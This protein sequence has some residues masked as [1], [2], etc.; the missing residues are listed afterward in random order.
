MNYS[1]ITFTLSMAALPLLALAEAD[2]SKTAQKTEKAP[3][4][5]E[6]DLGEV[7]AHSSA[8][9]KYVK[10]DKAFTDAEALALAKKS[11]NP[12]ANM[13]S[14][15]FQNNTNTGIGPDDSTQN[16][17]NVMPILPFKISDDIL[18]ISRTIIPIASQPDFLTSEG[19]GRVNGVADTNMQFF[20][21]PIDLGES[22]I[23]WGVGPS[24]LLPTAT[25]DSLGQEKWGAGISGILLAQPGRWVYGGVA[26]NIWSVG[27]A[28]EKD[29]NM[30]TLQY[31]V[32]YNFDGGWYI[33]TSPIMTADWEADTDHRWTVPLGGGFGKLFKI[34]SQ[35]L[36]AQVS[37]YKNVV[38]PDDYGA[39]W[40]VR[41]M[42]MWMFPRK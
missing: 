29:V 16:M 15:K 39:D 19:D 21:S 24:F 30:L 42:V 5:V 31:F 20:F 34:G 10:S 40:Q 9:L 25:D 35:P 33:L 26:S 37:A 4:Y 22:G 1:K 7:P 23:V 11:Q 38:T 12:I 32:N 28:G 36:T 41:A 14:F 3:E 13:R 2:I 8:E 17:L 6:T 27:G 18:V